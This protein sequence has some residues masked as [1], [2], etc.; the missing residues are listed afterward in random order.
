MLRKRRV[1]ADFAIG[2]RQAVGRLTVG[3][4]R[5]AGEGWGEGGSSCGSPFKRAMDGRL[6]SFPACKQGLAA[7]QP[8][9]IDE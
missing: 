5:P 9:I 2:K 6:N 8:N 4:R 3:G 1:Q 7:Y